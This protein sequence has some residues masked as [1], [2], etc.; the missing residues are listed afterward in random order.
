MSHDGRI[1]SKGSQTLQ[2]AGVK[3]NQTLEVSL[4]LKGGSLV[5]N[6]LRQ[7]NSSAKKTDRKPNNPNKQSYVNRES[8][9]EADGI[10]VQQIESVNRPVINQTEALVEML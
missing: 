8:P 6:M 2:N 4:P 3:A 5:K 1:L 7:R 9:N 10:Q